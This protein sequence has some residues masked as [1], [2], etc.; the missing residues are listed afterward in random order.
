MIFAGIAFGPAFVSFAME[1]QRHPDTA[2]AHLAAMMQGMYSYMIY[3]Y[4][5]GLLI[6]PIAYGLM[7]GQAAFAYRE[8]VPS[9]PT[10]P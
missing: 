6:A 7:L 1:V 4:V 8:L 9:V 2:N 3:A 5:I 10:R